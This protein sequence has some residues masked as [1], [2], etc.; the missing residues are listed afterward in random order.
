M[1]KLSKNQFEVLGQ[2]LLVLTSET[3]TPK[4]RLMGNVVHLISTSLRS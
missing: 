2:D 4:H 1:D 3:E